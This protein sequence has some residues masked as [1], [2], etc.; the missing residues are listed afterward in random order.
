MITIIFI[1]TLLYL[2]L[3]GSFIYG[4]DKVPS[5]QLEDIT[6]KTKFSII[7]PFRNEADH[8][9]LLLASISKL[10]YPKALY[11]I[12]LVDDDSEDNSLEIIKS[13]KLQKFDIS[14]VKN[15]RLTHSPK[16]DAITT[17][18]SHSKYDWIVTTD[19]DC[20]LPKYWLDTY[21][22]YIQNHKPKLLIA[23]VTF[24]T[25]ASFFDRFQLLDILS[26]QGVT[27]GGF[28]VNLPFMCNG[29]NMAY[30][31][32][33]FSDVK[34][35]EG[36]SH[37]ASGDDIFLLEK[38]LKA[39]KNAVHY[40]KSKDIVVST[41]PESNFKSLKSQRVRW[42]SKTSNYN[43]GFSKLTAL[44]V[45]FMNALLVCL[46][47]LCF[48]GIIS[49]KVFLYTCVIKFLID[50]LLIFKTARFFD[51]GQFLSSYFLSC[52]LYPFFSVYVAFISIFKGYKW[53]GRGYGK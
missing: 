24:T 9:P 31:K 22:H 25:I 32:A 21:D 36:N 35:F 46:P 16:K 3:I 50:F 5:F 37:I 2:L 29:A 17:A 6:A 20:S 53:K 34:G 12:I 40:I 45:L 7:I 41:N 42:A 13:S 47:L 19:A 23:P 18:I 48:S 44:V 51:Q 10:N 8:L 26:L 15:N 1:I 4:F 43:N 14:V 27:I 33:V 38:I 30:Q 52:L 11:E 28:G 49:V 39:N